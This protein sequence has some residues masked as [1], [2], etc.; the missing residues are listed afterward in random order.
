M[1]ND[2]LASIQPVDASNRGRTDITTASLRMLAFKLHRREQNYRQWLFHYTWSIVRRLISC[3]WT[4]DCGKECSSCGGQAVTRCSN[5][6]YWGDLKYSAEN[7]FINFHRNQVYK[8][9]KVNS[10][11]RVLTQLSA[12]WYS[13]VYTC[14]WIL[15]KFEWY[16]TS[17]KETGGAIPL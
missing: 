1:P 12:T 9:E 11:N 16:S 10:Y 2:R 3:E 8:R 14:P 4:G 17:E 13:F 6:A 5:T 15:R 7:P